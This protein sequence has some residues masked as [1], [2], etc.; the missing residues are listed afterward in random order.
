[1]IA[2]A[3]LVTIVR[4]ARRAVRDDP[5]AALLW[6]A[7]GALVVWNVLG[8][9]ARLETNVH[10]DDIAYTPFVRRLLDTGNLDEP[11]SFRRMSA[12]GGQTILQA[13]AGIRGTLANVH[14]L[15]HGIFQLITVALVAGYVRRPEI[16][17][18]TGA[19][20]LLVIV[21]LPDNSINTGTY[22]SGVALF[23]AIFRTLAHVELAPGRLYFVAG[24]LAAATCTLRQNYC[25][26]R[27]ARSG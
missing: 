14:L 3:S 27:S 18:F 24:L 8:A 4:D 21:L 10:D 6:I 16:D 19:L 20:L 2:E 5:H 9:V 12:L 17:R 7:L 26:S 1:M 23:L 15:D 25:R 22:W 13:L 11:F